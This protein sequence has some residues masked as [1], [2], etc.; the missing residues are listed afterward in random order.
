MV[1]GCGFSGGVG[2]GSAIL[3]SEVS[4]FTGLLSLDSILIYPTGGVNPIGRSPLFIAS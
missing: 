2:A 3:R 1:L 4:I